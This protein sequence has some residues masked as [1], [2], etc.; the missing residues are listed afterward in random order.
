MNARRVSARSREPLAALDHAT[1]SVFE[2]VHLGALDE[3]ALF[4]A[5][6]RGIPEGEARAMLT[7]AFVGEVIDGIADEA[8]RGVARAW[9]QQVLGSLSP[10]S[11]ALLPSKGQGR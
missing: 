2:L 1:L 6:Q 9:V 10:P 11:P 4:Y 8:A 3:D 7:E 5:R